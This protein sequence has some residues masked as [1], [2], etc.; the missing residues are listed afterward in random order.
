M[1]KQQHTLRVDSRT[2]R[3]TNLD[4]VLYPSTGTTKG[5]V[6][7]YYSTIAEVMLPHC[8]NR[9]A[10]RKRWPD[11]VGDDGRGPSFF[12]KD[13][14]DGAPDWLATGTIQHRDRVNTYPL[15]NDE[16]TLVWLAQ[17]A[18]LEIHVPQWRYDARGTAQA[19]DR[20]VFDLDPGDGVPLTRC[21][22]VAV[23]IRDILRDMGLSSAPLTSGGSGIHLYAALDGSVTSDQASKLARELARAME[24]DHPDEITSSMKRSLRPGKVFID[25]SQNNAAKTTVAPYS[26]RG[27]I[28][29]TVA[30]PRTWRELTSPHLRQL[31][32]H[33]VLARVAK[34]G[35]PLAQLLDAGAAAGEGARTDRLRTYRE[36]RDRSRTPEPVPDPGDDDEASGSRPVFV[37]QRH[38]ARRLHY[39]FRLEHDGVL[40][41][42]ALPKGP[43]TDPARNHL[44]V[45]TEDH[46]MSYRHFEGRIPAGEYGAGVVEIWDSGTYE[47]EKW[48]SDE[49][50]VTLTGQP[51]GGLGGVR[52]FALFRAGDDHGR[53]RWMIHLMAE[54]RASAEQ[55]EHFSPM[56]AQAGDPEQ[57]DRLD[58]AEWVFEMKWDGMRALAFADERGCV[59]RSRSGADVTAQYPELAELTYALDGVSAVLDGEII[60]LGSAGAPSFGLLQRR[61]GVTDA[62]ELARA[63]RE[64]PVSYVVFDVLSINGT[65]CVRLPYRERRQLL[66]HLMAEANGAPIALPEVFAA[67]RSATTHGSG[68]EAL[69]VSREL[70]LEG[71]V[72]K[73]RDS[74][75][76]P[77]TRSADWVKF[78]LIHTEEA[79][80]I[81]WRESSAEA[82]GLASLLLAE[83]APDSG[84]RY[85]GRVGT[86]FTVA[87]RRALLQRLTPLARAESVA[88]VPGDVRRDAHWVE[89]RLV[90]EVTSKGRTSAGRLRQPVWRGWR[91]D[92]VGHS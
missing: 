69:A 43:P 60:A 4:K 49:V 75:Y 64:A 12:H 66:E 13:L 5:D 71:I 65:T 83:R 25:W 36:K 52:R 31:E 79:V 80:V 30:A 38:Q 45:P 73:R 23:A 8:A 19:P 35:D 11:G 26:L 22:R 82:G 51:H 91:P 10:T 27:R 32:A 55:S 86:G 84:W 67:E 33:E 92:K 76:R 6:I 89:P 85:A 7:G 68:A 2:I 77:G 44:A 46:P 88:D 53:P 34:R 70:G 28:T 90:V 17:L 62:A 41:S 9:P 20:L 57:L 16:A 72:A 42:W 78:P 81:G 1:A 18:S 47:L 61:F 37:I 3:V 21:A 24:A 87:E 58:P 54:R 48:R 50:I 14:G 63:R 29:P 40:V 59:L 56:L 39:D 74:P 15:V